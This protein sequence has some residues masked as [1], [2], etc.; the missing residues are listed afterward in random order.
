MKITIPFSLFFI[1]NI[2]LGQVAISEVYY[3]SPLREYDNHGKITSYSDYGID[4]EPHKGEFIELF[5]YSDKDIDMS[6]WRLEDYG[7]SYTFPN[8]TIIKSNDFIILAYRNYN[9]DD[10]FFNFF[11]KSN[12]KLNEK[13]VLYQNN[14]ILFNYTDGL[15]LISTSY[16]GDKFAAGATA[17]EYAWGQYATGEDLAIS[18][19][20]SLYKAKDINKLS[21]ITERDKDGNNYININSFYQYSSNPVDETELTAGVG[22][23]ATYDEVHLKKANP[24]ELPFKVT[25]EPYENFIN[26]Y[27]IHSLLHYETLY[28]TYSHYLQIQSWLDRSC[29]FSV[30]PVSNLAPYDT[31]QD[32]YTF[33]Y[34]KSGN[35]T[36]YVYSVTSSSSSR[37]ATPSVTT[38]EIANKI[39]LYPVPTSGPLTIKWDASI[40][41][42]IGNI[43]I[44]SMIGNTSAIINRVAGSQTTNFDITTYPAGIY[45]VTFQ[46]TTGERIS[47][48]ISKY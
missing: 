15:R 45:I 11:N 3:D 21:D 12:K 36:D 40:D 19:R 28:D 26:K 1:S 34:D 23:L 27:K 18:N 46:L 8:E 24:F 31:Y 37:I 39:Y 30:D 13:K 14:L 4:Y 5:N 2:L 20:T 9:Q 44:T 17:Y 48:T 41:K 16:N 6:G 25:L 10:Y 32:K 38:D 42:F 35:R 33:S 47:K 29:N 22:Y 43:G 7:G